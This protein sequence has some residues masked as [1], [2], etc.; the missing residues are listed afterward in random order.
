MTDEQQKIQEPELK[1]DAEIEAEARDRGISIAFTHKDIWRLKN[2]IADL[3]GQK[4]S[5]EDYL[6]AHLDW[7]VDHHDQL[8]A[9][10]DRRRGN[11]PTAKPV[12][13]AKE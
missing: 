10:R 12:G 6:S 2:E 3:E 5:A 4:A 7:F 1:T 8:K 11:P 13:E 9:I